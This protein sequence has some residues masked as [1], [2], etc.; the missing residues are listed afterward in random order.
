MIQQS[1][2][3]Y[4]FFTYFLIFFF[5]TE[6]TENTERNFFSYFL[7]VFKFFLISITEKVVYRKLKVESDHIEKKINT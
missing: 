2:I 5:T 3:E 4:E 7:S 1:Y 6:N